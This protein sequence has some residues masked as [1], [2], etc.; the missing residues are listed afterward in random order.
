MEADSMKEIK[1]YIANLGRYHDGKLVGSWFTLPAN[2]EQISQRIGLDEQY[3][4]C[5][6]HDYDAPFAIKENES[7]DKLNEIAETL[8]DLS[9]EE[10]AALVKLIERGVISEIDPA[11][12]EEIVWYRDCMTMADV[13]YESYE[14]DGTLEQLTNYVPADY[15][16][17]ARIGRDM[18]RNGSFFELN[19]GTYIEFK[20]YAKRG[21][22]S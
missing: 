22:T 7:I 4:E 12:L 10:A 17:W 1:V 5:A 3:E 8:T 2:W 13:A 6:I 18:Q 9:D 19:D 15:I 14:S 21:L 16:D 11:V 20:H